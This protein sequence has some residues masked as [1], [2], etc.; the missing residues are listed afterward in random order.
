MI[1]RKTVKEMKRK[2][3]T[4]VLA[5]FMMVFLAHPTYASE[6]NSVSLDV[7][8]VS[9]LKKKIK[10]TIS[11]D[12]QTKHFSLRGN[13]SHTL[14]L[15]YN[16]AGRYAYTLQSLQT[17]KVYH[18]TV[19]VKNQQ[20]TLI[21]ETFVE[22]NNGEKTDEIVYTYNNKKVPTNQTATSNSSES[23]DATNADRNAGNTKPAQVGTG[24]DSTE[25][26]APQS[27]T[28]DQNV[29]KETFM[30]TKNVKTGDA[31]DV[32]SYVAGIILG[33][34]AMVVLRRKL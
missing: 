20:D 16:H 6:N 17:K 24:E 23:G 31:T 34:G 9:N 15:H 4:M 27:S 30:N 26:S 10:Y 14:T 33:L 11:S 25:M 7:K 28:E 5:C 1:K 13:G 19:L 3:M 18:I 32:F 21:P 29:T 8:Q 22:N 12:D 2:V